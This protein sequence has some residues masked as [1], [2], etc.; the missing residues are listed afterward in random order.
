MIL[1]FSATGNDKYVAERLSKENND[2]LVSLKKLVRENTYNLTVEEDEDF[3]IILPCYWGTA[4]TIFS[5]YIEKVNI[6]LKGNNHY[7]YFIGTYG[8]DYGKFGTRVQDMLKKHNIEFTSTFALKMV[9]NWNP[10]F[11]LTDEFIKTGE[12]TA[13]K[14]LNRV[15]PHIVNKE[16]GLFIEETRSEKEQLEMEKIYEDLRQ[17]KN[18]KVDLDKCIGCGLCARQCPL[19]VIEVSSHPEWIKDKCTLCLGCVHRCPVNAIV[20][21]DQTAGHGQFTNKNVKLDD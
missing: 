5:E 7:I 19:N 13:E 14:E 4:P 12:E 6:E 9:D 16:K 20:F 8:A 10:Y 1:Y 18:F 17:T 2:R 11:D 21:N 15:L 3:G